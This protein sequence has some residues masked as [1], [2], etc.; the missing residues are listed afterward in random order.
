MKIT[1]IKK[2]LGSLALLGVFT[3]TPAVFAAN[4]STT[5]SVR[6]NE[7]GIVHVVN[8]EITSISGNVIQAITH[9]KNNVANWTFITNASTTVAT[10]N[11]KAT[12]TTGLHIG[13]RLNVMGT[14]AALGSTISVN[15]SKIMSLTSHLPRKVTSGT[16]E[17]INTSNGT[18]VLVSGDKHITVQTNASTTFAFKPSASTTITLSSLALN[19]NVKVFG[20]ITNDG[21]AIIATKVIAKTTENNDDDKSKEKK[22]NNGKDNGLKNGWK[23]KEDR[24][25]RGEHKGFLK[26]DIGLGIGIGK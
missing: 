14:L 3:I 23:D 25:N 12:S 11:T 21:T 16:V 10:N 15:A 1:L 24:D 20:T 6:I 4:A 26:T 8:A 18:F 5:A 9:F 17:S 13:D 2:T 7:D 19:K 22:Y